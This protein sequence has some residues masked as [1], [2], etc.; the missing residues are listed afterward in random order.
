MKKKEEKENERK[1]NKEIKK[2]RNEKKK[3]KEMTK[4]NNKNK[5]SK[6]EYI[7]NQRWRH[8]Q[9][10]LALGPSR[11]YVLSARESIIYPL[12]T[13][14]IYLRLVYVMLLR[15]DPFQTQQQ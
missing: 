3:N 8:T 5:T 7:V 4:K 14:P 6:Q 11:H 13:F 15:P 2:K 12:Y 10:S 9:V 1:K